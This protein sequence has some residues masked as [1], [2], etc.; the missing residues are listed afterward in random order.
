MHHDD[1]DV[2]LNVCIGKE[3]GGATL[4][5]CGSLFDNDTHRKH[6]HT[7]THQRGRA[8]LH[9]GTHRHG[10][11]AITWGERYSLILWSKG[12]F[13]ETERFKLG[14]AERMQRG[15]KGDAPDL[16]CL[17][18]THD[19]DFGEFQPYPHGKEAHPAARRRHL[20]RFSSAEA[21][22]RATDLRQG[23]ADDFR[24]RDWR[25]AAAK[26]ESAAE[27]AAHAGRA[28]EPGAL[29]A[30]L[31]NEAQARLNLHE[32]SHA[33]HLCSRALELEP[34]SV[35]G[36]YRRALAALE[37]REYGAAHVDLLAAARLEPG[38][39]SVREK[40]ELSREGS[41]AERTQEREMAAA[42]MRSVRSSESFSKS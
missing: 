21:A 34:A 23:G 28:A 3:F 40:L 12:P 36:L 6:A 8:V 1:S 11:D 32:P 15:T 18:Y 13:R 9:L 4:T 17:S 30:L 22:G 2:T 31:L 10:A 39:R 37:M 24:R 42:M 26:Y 41:L 5:F 33:A 38:N 20:D 27:Y 16:V 14:Y 35:K 19:P 7:Y 25:A 29:C